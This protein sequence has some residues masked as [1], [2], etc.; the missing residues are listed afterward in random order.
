MAGTIT[1]SNVS[2]AFDLGYDKS[3]RELIVDITGTS[4]ELEVESLILGFV[5]AAYQGLALTS[6]GAEPIGENIWKG[7]ARYELLDSEWSFDTGGGTAKFTQSYGT[8]ASYA[9]VGMTAPDFQGAIGVSDDAVEGVEIESPKYDWTETKVW[10]DADVSDA[11]KDAIYQLT[12]SMNN[13]SFR[14]KAAGE[15]KFKGA[16]GSKRGNGL[17][18]ITYHFSASPNVTGASYGG[19]TGI[20]KLGWDYLWFRYASFTDAA[21]NCLI[22]K[23]IA[24]YVERVC[25]IG[26]FSTL[27]I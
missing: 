9:P 10:A 15:C 23:P 6:W 14:G 21:A 26:D 16:T 24:A 2:R 8:I 7:H 13:A 11:Y 22:K 27:L 3:S 19:I 17:W 5:P 18:T 12:G 1:E 25:L 20:D 4:D